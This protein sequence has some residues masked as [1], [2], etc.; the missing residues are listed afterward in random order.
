MLRAQALRRI[1]KLR[2]REGSVSL[3]D[4]VLAYLVRTYTTLYMEAR[5]N[6]A[7][8]VQVSTGNFHHF[9]AALQWQS[10]TDRPK[11]A[12]VVLTERERRDL[13]REL[14]ASARRARN[15]TR[16]LDAPTLH[17]AFA[18][19]ANLM[20]TG[21]VQITHLMREVREAR[22]AQRHAEDTIAAMNKAGPRDW[23]EDFAHEN[24]RYACA[25]VE[26]R[27]QFVGH[28]RRVL[29]RACAKAETIPA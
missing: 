4:D 2:A 23:S 17:K 11:G 29:C 3:T 24:G 5:S 16:Q 9:L 19:C 25:C 21:G 12:S 15:F 13:A 7:P 1:R 22:E 26:C 18:E 20:E 10:A 14:T 8:F 27:H 6:A 28:K